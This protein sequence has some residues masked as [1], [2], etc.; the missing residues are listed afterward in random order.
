MLNLAFADYAHSWKSVKAIEFEFVRSEINPQFA[1]IATPTE[2][3]VTTSFPI[4]MGST[5]G[6]LHICLPYAMIEPVRDQLMSSLH[7]ETLDTDERWSTLLR[8]Q[9][10]SS[11]VE[12]RSTFTELTMSV[13]D[14]L[15]LDVGDVLPIDIPSEV[16]ASVDGV[17]VLKGHYGTHKQ[18]YALKVT[19]LIS[20]IDP[21]GGRI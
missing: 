15:S 7:G 14:L 2:V 9:L 10:T 19:G 5:S 3:V 20:H 13:E 6:S 8:Y 4:E 17:K 21:T 12:L 1:N 11:T 18:R 16:S